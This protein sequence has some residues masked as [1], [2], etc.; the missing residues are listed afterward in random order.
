MKTKKI[1]KDKVN[2]I[3]LGCSKNMV[4]SE[5]LMHQ[6]KVNDFEVLHDSEE[7]ANIVIINTC[8]FIDRAKE[9]SINTI[10]LYAEQRAEG[11]IDKLYVTGCLSER[12]KVDLE[13]EIPEVDA[14]FGTMELPALMHKLEADYKQEL[15]GERVLLTPSHYAYLKISEGCSRT[16]TFCAIPLMRGKHI[17][18]TIEDLVKE[19]K[20]LAKNGVK[21][22]M[23]IAQELTYYGLDIYKKRA[24]SELL[25]ALNAVE[26]IEWIRLHYAYPSKFPLEVLDTINELPKVC[27]YLDMPLQHISNPVLKAMRRQITKEETRELIETAREKVPGITI[28]TTFLVGFP[29]ETEADFQELLDFVGEM[30][31]ERVG[32][33]QYSHEENTDAYALTDDIPAKIKEERA[34]RLMDLQRDI[35]AEL[36]QEKIGL[37]M[38]ILIDRKESGHFIGRSEF[39]SPEVDNEVL[40]EAKGNTYLRIGDFANVRIIDSTEYDLF[41][42]PIK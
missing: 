19:T 38:R 9:E 36:N 15:I 37:E 26:G 24:L 16:C 18:K 34:N 42:E 6:L 13:R 25:T 28:R 30:R 23:L 7:D 10:L 12:Y 3:T 31:F 17:S 39:D 2:V 20:G 27:K 11:N 5:I 32:V 40:I 14:Y 8:G 29:G 1:N 41:A 33:F 22:I 4:D 35:S 21:E